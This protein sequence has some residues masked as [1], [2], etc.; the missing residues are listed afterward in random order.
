MEAIGFL[1]AALLG[2]CAIPEVW[3]TIKHKRCFIGDGFLIMWGF[4][5]ILLIIYVLPTGQLPLL[6]NYGFNLVLVSIL[7]YYRIQS[8]IAPKLQGNTS[9][10]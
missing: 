5:E 1:G 9:S 3:R 10:S 7:A 4:G 8:L 2:C 6:L